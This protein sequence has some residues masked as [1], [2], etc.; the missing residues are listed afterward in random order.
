MVPMQRLHD[1]RQVREA[2]PCQCHGCSLTHARQHQ[3][4]GV[5]P[6]NALNNGGLSSSRG[7]MVVCERES[8]QQHLNLMTLSCSKPGREYPILQ[9]SSDSRARLL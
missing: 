7:N 3:C 4:R 8:G 9:L 2:V 5:V 1:L 6:P